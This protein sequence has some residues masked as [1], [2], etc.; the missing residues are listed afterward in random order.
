MLELTLKL[1]RLL[2]KILEITVILVMGFLVF[3]V[4]WGVFTRF[5]WHHQ[6]SWTEELA[7]MLLVWV[8]LLGAGIGFIRGSHLGVDYFVGKLSVK[9]QTFCQIVVY[10]LVAIFAS[11]IMIYGGIRLVVSTLQAGQ[12]SPAL[13]L[14]VGYVYL[15]VPISGFFIFVFSFETIIKNSALLLRKTE[16]K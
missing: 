8:S 1:I 2:I 6:S 12:I 15:V 16:N 13:R 11:V 14:P 7:R 10:L 5:V 9:K 4:L 3:D